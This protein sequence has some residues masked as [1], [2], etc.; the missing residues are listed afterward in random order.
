MPEDQ[1]DSVGG[2]LAIGMEVINRLCR[3]ITQGT[4]SVGARE[5][6][7]SIL[8]GQA[9]VDK[10]EDVSPEKGRERRRDVADIKADLIGQGRRGGARHRRCGQQ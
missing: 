6:P 3:S 8:G 7:N 4:A 1:A 5:K 10:L 9:V 2:D